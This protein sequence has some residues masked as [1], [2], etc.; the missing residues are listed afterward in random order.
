LI[1]LENSRLLAT[2]GEKEWE[3][4]DWCSKIK[5]DG[6]VEEELKGEQNEEEDEKEEEEEKGARKEADKVE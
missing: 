4:R 6:E 3:G 1:L 5:A 2:R